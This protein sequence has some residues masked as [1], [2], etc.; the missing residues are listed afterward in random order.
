MQS[1]LLWDHRCDRFELFVDDWYVV[2]VEFTRRC[3]G[4]SIGGIQT[5]PYLFKFPFEFVVR[6]IVH[7]YEVV[8]TK[9]SART[10]TY[11]YLFWSS[12]SVSTSSSAADKYVLCRNPIRALL[13]KI[14][15]RRIKSKKRE[16]YRQKISW[17][18]RKAHKK[19]YRFILWKVHVSSRLVSS[20]LVS[21]DIEN[22]RGMNWLC[23]YCYHLSLSPP[24]FKQKY[25][26]NRNKGK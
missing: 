16:A 15:G 24:R 14:V 25:T 22:P 8:E 4:V 10:T 13:E 9:C 5:H 23:F 6:R 17:K 2:V 11:I 12:P 1:Y 3:W 7:H 19:F 20:R 21:N 26:N 18:Y